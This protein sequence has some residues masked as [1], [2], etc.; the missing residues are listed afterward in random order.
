MDYHESKVGVCLQVSFFV[1]FV[2]YTCIKAKKE[3]SACTSTLRGG[4]SSSAITVIIDT[5]HIMI[6]IMN[7]IIRFIKSSHFLFYSILEVLY[8][9]FRTNTIICLIRKFLHNYKYY[10]SCCRF[11]I[12]FESRC[13]PSTFYLTTPHSGWLVFRT[14]HVLNSVYPAHKTKTASQFRLN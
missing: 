5:E 11:T 9:K 2:L 12:I 8:N 6:Q 13:H 4:C 14:L 10:F 1:T 3:P 7:N